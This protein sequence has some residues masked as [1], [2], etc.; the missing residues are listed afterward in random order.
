VDTSYGSRM[1]VGKKTT[2]KS[3]SKRIIGSYSQILEFTGFGGLKSVGYDMVLG[4][5]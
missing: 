1:A 5:P 2:K 3:L 4:K